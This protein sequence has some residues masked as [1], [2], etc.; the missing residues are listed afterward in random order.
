M[1]WH[2]TE[3]M[4]MTR[5][6]SVIINQLSI[7]TKKETKDILNLN[8]VVLKNSF[9]DFINSSQFNIE[10]RKREFINTSMNE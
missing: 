6:H 10:M 8:C 3:R 7:P 1:I 9:I 2:T 5:T 4:T